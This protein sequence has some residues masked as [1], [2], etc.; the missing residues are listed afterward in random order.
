MGGR[1][2][3]I[4]PKISSQVQ[5]LQTVSTRR[6]QAFAE[7]YDGMYKRMVELIYLLLYH[8]QVGS[9]PY[10]IGGFPPFE[11]LAGLVCQSS[12]VWTF[13]LNHDLIFQL[14]AA[15]CNIPLRDG[16]W[17]DKTLA[18]YGNR[19]QNAM[20]DDWV[21]VY[22]QMDLHH[23]K[24]MALSS[25]AFALVEIPHTIGGVARSYKSLSRAE[26]EAIRDRTPVDVLERTRAKEE[27]E[28]R[29][30]EQN[31]HRK[32]KSPEKWIFLGTVG[33]LV[34]TLLL[35]PDVRLRLGLDKPTAEVTQPASKPTAP[36]P[37]NDP[38]PEGKIAHAQQR[39]ATRGEQEFLEKL[40]EARGDRTNVG[41]ASRVFDQAARLM[42]RSYDLEVDKRQLSEARKAF[43][44]GDF[45]TAADLF[46]KAFA[47][48]PNPTGGSSK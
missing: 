37:S 7:Q 42:P 45:Q 40:A 11:G 34:A 27:I 24:D 30:R 3:L 43:N 1:S 15:H 22:E 10:I 23:L 28:R 29:N 31:K 48:V 5:R 33:I 36:T 4:L 9:L 38:R 8:R 39:A 21:E 6:Q 20:R 26:L 32:W 25:R 35:I 16:F 12:P 46:E 14:L 13:S 17:P 18:V 44:Q 47:G 19:G 41:L 2:S